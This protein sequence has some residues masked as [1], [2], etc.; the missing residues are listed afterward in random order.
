MRHVCLLLLLLWTGWSRAGETGDLR[1]IQAQADL[2][3]IALWLNLPAAALLEPEQFSISVGANPAKVTAIDTFR[4][5]GEGVAYIFLVDISKS[6]KSRQFEQI[7][8]ALRGWLDGMGEQDRGAL[9]S[10]GREVKQQLD[11]TGDRDALNNA[12][13]SLAATDMETGLYRGLL[14]GI[15]LGRRQNQDL[16]ARRAIVVLSD[17]I[18]DSLKGVAVDEV[19]KQSQEYR[20]PIYSIG[21]TSQPFSESKREGLRVLSRLSRQSGG[22][23]VQ[24]ESAQLND[25]YQQ[26]Q[27]SITQAYRL[28]LDCPDCRADGQLH[29][30]NVTWSDGQQTLSDGFDLRLL[31]KSTVGKP[32]TADGKITGMPEQLLILAVAAIALMVGMLLIYRQRLARARAAILEPIIEPGVVEKNAQPSKQ[33]TAG[34]EVRLTVVAGMRKGK[35]YGL[36]IA[37]RAT[38]GRAAS[39]ELV[40]DDDV[41]ISGQHAMLRIADGKLSVRDLNSTNGTLVN[42]VPIHNDYPLR[43]GDLLLLGRT[44]LRIELAGPA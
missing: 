10:F 3:V 17:G 6:I 29:R 15:S 5:T 28:R 24:A 36:R 2:P 11:F 9:I 43:R 20:V 4:Q 44:E 37:E 23:F 19:F 40:L 1:L 32:L 16:P 31:P 39:C 14:E 13:D 42:G 12:I 34:Y 21:F 26:L 33:L 25:A 8:S 27:Q 7:K 41:E 38:L 22:Y 30:I 18:D 35:T